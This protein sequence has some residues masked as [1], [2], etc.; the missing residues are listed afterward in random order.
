MADDEMAALRASVQPVMAALGGA[1]EH[2]DTC[3]AIGGLVCF[4]AVVERAAMLVVARAR[5]NDAR[6]CLRFACAYNSA[7][8]CAKKYTPNGE[9]C[10]AWHQRLAA[11]E[12]RLEAGA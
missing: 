7:E 8:A 1:H 4:W 3:R 6:D 10:C 2:D 9:T 12:A 5:V 11:A